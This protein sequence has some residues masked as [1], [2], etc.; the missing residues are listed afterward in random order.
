MG[1][2]ALPNGKFVSEIAA[3]IP[4]Q[5]VILVGSGISKPP[6]SGLPVGEDLR[7]AILSSLEDVELFNKLPKSLRNKLKFALGGSV[8]Q[9]SN[10]EDNLEIYGLPFEG[11]LEIY[12]ELFPGASDIQDFLK[13]NLQATVSNWIHYFLS[14]SLLHKPPFIPALIT[15][16]YDN[17]IEKAV[18]SS[19][20]EQVKVYSK[21]QY[22]SWGKKQPIYFKVHGTLEDM[23]TVIAT[24]S[25]ERGL[26]RWKKCFFRDLMD[27]K[28]LLILGYSGFDF[29]VC[30][31]IMRA[32]PKK[33]YWNTLRKEA[34]L[35]R[36]A[37]EILRSCK[38][39]HMYGDAIKFINQLHS[40]L[41]KKIPDFIDL[42]MKAEI[43]KRSSDN[44]CRA[45][46][47]NMFKKDNRKLWLIQASIEA[48]AGTIALDLL[49][50]LESEPNLPSGRLLLLL[51]A[52]ARATFLQEDY[53]ASEIWYLR[54]VRACQNKMTK[55]DL[56]LSY[57]E[58]CRLQ[59]LPHGGRGGYL[60]PLSSLP[61]WF[62]QSITL[63]WKIIW[64][65]L[66]A[67][68]L[69]RFQR[70]TKQNHR[71]RGYLWLRLAQVID[72][73][74][75][76]LRKIPLLS[77]TVL[78]FKFPGL[79]CLKRADRYFGMSDNYFGT[80]Q[81]QRIRLR[82]I[83]VS[84]QRRLEQAEQLKDYYR[85][86]GYLT[87]WSNSNR[88]IINIILEM[89]DLSRSQLKYMQ[90]LAQEALQVSTLVDDR[91]GMRKA[92]DLIKHLEEK[93]SSNT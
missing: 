65:W 52:K 11:L 24:L 69:L 76:L 57:F 63:I 86:L 79:W 5:L 56:W 43:L 67:F 36:D 6:P 44:H 71:A 17:L 58:A 55:A 70:G 22:K 50:E 30:P 3:C 7:G 10:C 80:Q 27:S 4:D 28:A 60:P 19:Y 84:P 41:T 49:H 59:I 34:K 46:D 39:V 40:E 35:P 54:A 89:P 77:K 45:V 37:Y 18:S 26:A 64:S 72:N 51:R 47:T 88:D 61:F 38:G 83:A 12:E 48:G 91:P 92:K 75:Q 21:G 16:N 62:L 2:K 31:E 82:L 20:W 66:V 1:I 68:I 90:Q 32:H 93:N 9:S 33:V 78:F 14:S 74:Y 85:R 29:D 8:P 81:T 53:K 15:T 87:A 23:E 73:I 42:A 25:A 13:H